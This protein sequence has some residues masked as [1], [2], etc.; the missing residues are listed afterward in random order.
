[1]IWP[2][3]L[4][5]NRGRY[6]L[7]TGQ[8]VSAAEALKLGVVNEILPQA[9]LLPRTYE[10]A[11]TIIARPS[12]AVRYARVAM[13]QQLKKLMLENLGYGLALEGLSAAAS[14][15]GAKN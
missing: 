13:T 11:R 14:W 7:L 6:L 2:L 4:G 15:P 3:L 8:K 10:L 12:L 1:V 9:Q 5:P